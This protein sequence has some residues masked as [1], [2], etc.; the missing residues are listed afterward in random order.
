MTS[1]IE[2]ATRLFVPTRRI[3]FDLAVAA[4]ERF[5]GQR[6]IRIA[7]A[8]CSEGLLSERIALRHPDWSIDAID[9]DSRPWRSLGRRFARPA[10]TT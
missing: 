8:G 10:F 4:V 7:D 6:S 1:R 3:R 9:L 2:R 5:A